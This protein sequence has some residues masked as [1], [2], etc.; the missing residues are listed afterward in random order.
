MPFL[1][2]ST[3]CKYFNA[4]AHIHTNANTFSLHAHSSLRSISRTLTLTHG[5][6]IISFL[7]A[8][9]DCEYSKTHKQTNK[10]TNTHTHTHTPTYIYR[11]TLEH[12]HIYQLKYW[13]NFACAHLDALRDEIFNHALLEGQHGLRI[14][15]DTQTNKHA[16]TYTHTYTD[17]RTPWRTAG[18]D[19]QSCP[20]WK[21]ARIENTPTHTNKQ[22]HTH[23]HTQTHLD[24][25]R[26]EIFNHALLEGQ[27][28][29]W[30]AQGFGA[31]FVGELA[32][33][34]RESKNSITGGFFFE[35]RLTDVERK[36]KEGQRA[37]A[38]KQ[39]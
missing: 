19:F 20:S 23:I 37:R 27:H 24:A 14:L 21:P 36:K 15:Q 9:T 22:T 10:Q 7:K 29:L 16:H 6:S 2:A 5:F 31:I 25:L 11:H 28:G 18:R 38:V 39:A 1:K 4:R 35:K 13:V 30:I 3:D 8:N 34:L 26:D 33:D 32:R 17:T 12:R